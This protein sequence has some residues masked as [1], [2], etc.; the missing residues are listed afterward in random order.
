MRIRR[1]GAAGA[2]ARVL[3]A[4]AFLALAFVLFNRQIRPVMESETVNE[5]KVRSV[6]IINTV[7][8]H[9]I[10]RNEVSYE[11]LVSVNRDTDGRVLSITS[12]VPKMNRLKAEIISDVQQG[13]DGTGESGED[14]PLGTLL[15][16]N[17]FHGYGPRLHLKITLAGNVKADFKSTFESAG[18]NQTRHQIFLNVGA[19]VY[20]FL[21]GVS[22]T[23]DVNTN[24]L[25]AET[26]IVGEVPEVLV[27]SK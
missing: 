17:L 8:L 4:L 20:S 10:D 24:V 7:V 23:T 6:G 15:G 14:I 9:E 25:V 16:S 19:S 18:I 3:L 12:D 5:A 11:N 1:R 26:V 22:E 13:L 27:N 2:W 21:P